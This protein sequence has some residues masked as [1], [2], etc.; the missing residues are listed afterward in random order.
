MSRDNLP[1]GHRRDLDLT[2]VEEEPLV[3]LKGMNIRILKE[4]RPSCFR[5][6][7]STRTPMATCRLFRHQFFCTAVAS[8][9]A[10]ASM[11]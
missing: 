9:E 11:S 6:T 8:R 10:H 7:I 5:W 1:P 2:W 4:H 3:R